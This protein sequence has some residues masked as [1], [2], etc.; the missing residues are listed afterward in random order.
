[1]TSAEENTNE[2]LPE[3]RNNED[4]NTNDVK[5]PLKNGIHD[6]PQIIKGGTDTTDEAAYHPDELE[7]PLNGMLAKRNK[8]RKYRTYDNGKKNRINLSPL[9]SNGIRIEKI[10]KQ[11]TGLTRTGLVLAVLCIVLAIV[12]LVCL[13]LWPKTSHSKE[14]PVCAKPSC[15]R[16]SAEVIISLDW[17]EKIDPRGV[18]VRFCEQILSTFHLK[19]CE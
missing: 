15:L 11:K 5:Q 18:P 19:F 16:S 14:Y 7:D 8:K 6:Q 13:I 9:K 3:Q 1:M 12:L 2:N 4:K 10:I 17:Y